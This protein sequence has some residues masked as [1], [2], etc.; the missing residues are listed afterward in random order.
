M[1]MIAVL[2]RGRFGCAEIGKRLPVIR[3]L[4]AAAA[5][6]PP[7][8]PVQL[9]KIHE[10]SFDTDQPTPGAGHA[11]LTANDAFSR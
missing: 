9:A 4:G 8:S 10:S 6:P 1:L 5:P 11:H 2:A 3:N 7:A